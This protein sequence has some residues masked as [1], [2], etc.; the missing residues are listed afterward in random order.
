MVE[1]LKFKANNGDEYILNGDFSTF[2]EDFSHK[3]MFS[4]ENT[5]RNNTFTYYISISHQLWAATWKVDEE[6]EETLKKVQQVYLNKA[7]SLIE[8]GKEEFLEMT[9]TPLNS[10]KELEEALGAV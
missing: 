3:V 2:T 6:S 7:K 10:P 9:M 8:Q 1:N 4:I 5:T